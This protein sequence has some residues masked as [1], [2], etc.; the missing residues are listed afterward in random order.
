MY[1]WQAKGWPKTWSGAQ[2]APL[3]A[4]ASRE[5]GCLLGKMEAL[6]FELRNEAHLRTLTEDVVKTSDTREGEKLDGE[7]VRS[8]LA[9]R[10]GL[11]VGGLVPADRNVDGV[12][13]MMLDAT[14]NHSK[15]LTE[16][17]LFAWHSHAEGRTRYHALAGMV[18]ELSA[19]GDAGS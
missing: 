3:L 8:S 9:R 16:A 18:P 14:G 5:Q 15:P 11:D 4:R 17:R 12:V 10:L 13:D 6:G 1:L 19:T 7:Q 2:L